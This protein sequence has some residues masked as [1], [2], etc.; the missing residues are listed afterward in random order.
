MCFKGQR[1]RGIFLPVAVSALKHEGVLYVRAVLVLAVQS[2]LGGARQQAIVCAPLG[3][4]KVSATRNQRHV[5]AV[6]R[7]WLLVFVSIRLGM[8]QYT[9]VWRGW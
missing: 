9:T 5:R 2:R 3:E 4:G 6:L 8:P 7:P 1:V